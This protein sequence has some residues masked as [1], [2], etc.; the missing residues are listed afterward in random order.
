V[1]RENP[2]SR[3]TETSAEVLV[4][5]PRRMVSNAGQQQW[6]E[7]GERKK[8]L[9]LLLLLLLTTRTE[10]ATSPTSTNGKTWCE[11]LESCC[12]ITMAAWRALHRAA[13]IVRACLKESVHT[14]YYLLLTG[15][16]LHPAGRTDKNLCR[17][18]GAPA[19]R[20]F[21]DHLII[22]FAV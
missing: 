22:L 20:V 1:I 14:T 3:G 5:P 7:E 21:P 16:R 12:T 9:L 17:C 4:G 8:N 15:V 10:K 19:R 11:L 6:Y 13:L 2:A 18:F